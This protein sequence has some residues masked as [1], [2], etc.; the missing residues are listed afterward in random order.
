MSIGIDFGH[1][2][3]KISFIENNNIKYCEDRL[4]QGNHSTRSLVQI[5]EKNFICGN[6]YNANLN[7]AKTYNVRSLFNK[8]CD[9]DENEAIN[10]YFKHLRRCCKGFFD[11][12]INL[13]VIINKSFIDRNENVKEIIECGKNVGF[14]IKSFIYNPIPEAVFEFENLHKNIDNM[15]IIDIGGKTSC[16]SLVDI[17]RKTSCMILDVKSVKVKIIKALSLFNVST[18]KIFEKL[19][20]YC[21]S[22]YNNLSIKEKDKYIFNQSCQKVLPQFLQDRTD[23]ELRLKDEEIKLTYD[24]YLSINQSIFL[25][26]VNG[27]NQIISLAKISINDIG[28]IT[29]CGGGNI[30][31]PNDIIENLLGQNAEHHNNGYL[32]VVNGLACL[33]NKRYKYVNPKVK[34]RLLYDIGLEIKDDNNNYTKV[35]YTKDTVI[36]TDIEIKHDFDVKGNVSIKLHEDNNKTIIE[37]NNVPVENEKLQ[38]KICINKN[39]ECKLKIGDN[40]VKFNLTGINWI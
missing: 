18:E 17:G 21:Y 11:E 36:E 7:K 4:C 34:P 35:F 28:H 13:N 31:I 37:I 19:F 29:L 26:I 27:I 23:V 15:L 24:D 25:D 20:Y 5:N 2:N 3:S 12:N 1:I 32:Y 30:F 33:T 6:S 14:N 22:K 8:E 38:T 9:G 16:I 40:E 39:F 10:A